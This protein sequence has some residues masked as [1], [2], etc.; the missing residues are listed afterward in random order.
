[1]KDPYLIAHQAY[2]S[3]LQRLA[4]ETRIRPHKGDYGTELPR[5]IRSM[6]VVGVIVAMIASVPW[7]MLPVPLS[8]R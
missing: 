2:L 5:Q 8:L 3:D 6:L 1:M 4:E 7:D